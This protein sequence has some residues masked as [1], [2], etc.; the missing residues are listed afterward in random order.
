MI[1]KNAADKIVNSI[2]RERKIS[3]RVAGKLLQNYYQMFDK[4]EAFLGLYHYHSNNSDLKE[5]SRGVL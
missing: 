5:C 2:S 3:G 1:D 4:S